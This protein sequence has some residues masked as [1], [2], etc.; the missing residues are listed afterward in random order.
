MTKIAFTILI[1][2]YYDLLFI[3][4]FKWLAN[5]LGFINTSEHERVK[6]G[7]VAEAWTLEWA[8]GEGF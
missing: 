1:T 8:G 5:H 6:W 2:F 4:H 3:F 7:C